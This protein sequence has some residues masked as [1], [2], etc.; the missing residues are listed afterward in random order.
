MNY[1]EETIVDIQKSMS[2]VMDRVSKINA[3][4]LSYVDIKYIR[5]QLMS[6]LSDTGSLVDDLMA[7]SVKDKYG[8]YDE[9]PSD[10]HDSD[11]LITDDFCIEYVEKYRGHEVRVILYKSTGCR[12]GYVKLQQ[13]IWDCDDI[14]C[15]GDVTFNANVE[16]DD[17]RFGGRPGHWI[18]FECA[19]SG[20]STDRDAVSRYFHEEKMSADNFYALSPDGTVRS[21]EYVLK[22]CYH[23][24]DQLIDEVYNK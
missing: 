14:E 12:C 20:D 9:D 21:A 22:E 13:P 4:N 17:D 3:D 6:A 24:V 19:H 18:G 10:S 11:M 5:E 8:D 7:E 15:H 23:I 1:T 2:K 16:I